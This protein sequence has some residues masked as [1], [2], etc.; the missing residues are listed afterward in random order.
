MAGS[1]GGAAVEAAPSAAAPIGLTLP[2]SLRLMSS[3][4][5]PRVRGVQEP[6]RLSRMRPHLVQRATVADRTR[7]RQ[8]PHVYRFCD[9]TRTPATTIAGWRAVLRGWCHATPG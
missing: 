2:V 5:Q 4:G 1:S 3:S 8:M 6:Y 7:S 9:G